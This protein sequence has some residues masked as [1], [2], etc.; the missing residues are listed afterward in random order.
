MRMRLGNAR[1]QTWER[2]ASGLG[3]VGHQVWWQAFP[4]L[5]ATVPRLGGNR[6]H[7]FTVNL[8]FLLWFRRDLT[9]KRMQFYR[10]LQKSHILIF[11]NP[12]AE[13]QHYCIKTNSC[14]RII[15]MK[16]DWNYMSHSFT[17]LVTVIIWNEGPGDRQEGVRRGAG[18][19]MTTPRRRFW[20]LVWGNL[21]R[22]ET[23][24]T[25]SHAFQ[26]PF[27]GVGGYIHMPGQPF[28]SLG[29]FAQNKNLI[30]S[31]IK[32]HIFSLDR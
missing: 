17:F 9:W 22:K 19:S 2:S 10:Q 26:A 21:I 4:G 32:C 8:C 7:A 1:H 6:S 16:I 13:N 18:G 30:L 11:S 24:I 23:E 15:L 20:E 27:H 29:I 31:M 5:M 12:M 3:T 28:I 25:M 14:L